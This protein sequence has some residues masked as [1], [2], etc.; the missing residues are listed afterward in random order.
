MAKKKAKKKTSKAVTKRGSRAVSTGNWQDRMSA[1]AKD[2]AAR[3]G[4]DGGN[5]ISTRNGELAVGGVKLNYPFNCVILNFARWRNYFEVPFDGENPAPACCW[6]VSES[7]ARADV[8][9]MVPSENAFIPQADACEGC[10]HNEF[11]D[12]G[13]KECRDSVL[14][15]LIDADDLE[16]IDSA[17]PLLLS[18]PPTSLTNFNGFTKKCNKVHEV[19][20]YGVICSINKGEHAKSGGWTL[21]FTAE[22]LISDDEYSEET[23]DGLLQ[24]VD[25]S[26]EAVVQEPDM[27]LEQYQEAIGGQR[28]RGKKKRVAKKKRG[29]RRR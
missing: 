13:G 29:G 6:S 2:E 3:L 18:I 27:T 12:G 16:D 10:P 23:L 17:E 21:E 1:A 25:S 14:V 19:P 4:G 15:Q 11:V 22:E 9:A 8:L 20:T 24:L 5:K 26:A 28:K 7:C